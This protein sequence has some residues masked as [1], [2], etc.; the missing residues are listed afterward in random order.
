MTTTHDKLVEIGKQYAKDRQHHIAVVAATQSLKG[1]VPSF[2]PS[3]GGG[4]PENADIGLFRFAGREYTLT[5][6]FG[7]TPGGAI[8]RAVLSRAG[9][10]GGPV[11][12]LHY[13]PAGV[14]TD[15]TGQP[16]GLTLPT[17]AAEVVELLLLMGGA[18]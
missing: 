5:H 7:W 3:P 10:G 13:G 18:G 15:P 16:T 9:S 2:G 12:E 4:M 1:Q 8:S 6:R 14:V 11:S 17:D